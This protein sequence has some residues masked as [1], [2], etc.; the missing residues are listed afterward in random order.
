MG[1]YQTEVFWPIFNGLEW[2]VTYQTKLIDSEPDSYWEPG[3]ELWV[4]DSGTEQIDC[5]GVVQIWIPDG[6]LEELCQKH[7]DNKY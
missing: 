7:F 4:L 1:Q 3:Y 6:L 2:E 5:D